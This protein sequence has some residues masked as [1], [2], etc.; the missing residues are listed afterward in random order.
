[1]AQAPFKR[2]ITAQPSE[3]N[4]KIYIK[5]RPDGFWSDDAI[6]VR[7]E[8]KSE[9][10]SH[11]PES[12][13]VDGRFFEYDITHSSGGREK[14]S[15]QLES[16]KAFHAA[17]ADAI[18]LVELAKIRVSESTTF[19]DLMTEMLQLGMDQETL[20]TPRDDQAIITLVNIGDSTVAAAGQLWKSLEVA[21]Q[22]LGALYPRASFAE[23][24]CDSAEN[25]Y[26][27]AMYHHCGQPIVGDIE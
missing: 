7:I 13:Q 6:T 21:K 8:F 12:P 27:W 25:I 24:E 16:A 3:H 4:S 19:K 11:D 22:E 23:R 17:Y 5:Y 1:M 2:V 26:W 14:G 9:Y 10:S 15:D 20:R 18:E